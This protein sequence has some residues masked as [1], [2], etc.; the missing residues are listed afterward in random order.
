MKKYLG[1]NML[2]KRSYEFEAVAGI[3]TGV[4]LVEVAFCVEIEDPHP[5]LDLSIG[6]GPLFLCV[7]LFKHNCGGVVVIATPGEITE[8]D[9]GKAS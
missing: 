6:L 3:N 1:F 2:L 7:K 5:G 9:D 8:K 4:F